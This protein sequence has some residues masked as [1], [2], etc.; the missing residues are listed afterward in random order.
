MTKYFNKNQSN[1]EDLVDD[2]Q[3]EDWSLPVEDGHQSCDVGQTLSKQNPSLHVQ[4]KTPYLEDDKNFKYLLVTC[5]YV[6]RQYGVTKLMGIKEAK[7]K[8]PGL[9]IVS[10]EDLTHYREMSYKISEFLQKYT[11]NVERLGFDENFLDVSE[12]VDQRLQNENGDMEVNGHIYGNLCKED[13]EKETELPVTSHCSCGCRSRLIIGSQ[14]ANEIREALNE[15]LGITCCAGISY[16]KLLSKL[17]GGQH[18]PNQQTTLFPEQTSEFML[19]LSR[20]RDIPGVGWTTSK[21]LLTLGVFSVANLQEVPL[22]DL[23]EEIG[24]ASAMHIKELSFGIDD[25]PVVPFKRPQTLSDEDSFKKCSTE[26]EVRSKVRELLSSLMIRLK[27]DGRIPHT[28]RLTIRRFTTTN[29]YT[30]RESRQC[31]ISSNVFS[32]TDD[33]M[34]QTVNKLLDIVMSLFHKLVNVNQSFHLTLINIAFCNLQDKAKK[35]IASFFSPTKIKNVNP[36]VQTENIRHREQEDSKGSENANKSAKSPPSNL[37]KWL[38]SFN[39]GRKNTLN[40]MSD[41]D[42]MGSNSAQTPENKLD[43]VTET[44]LETPREESFFGIGVKRK[45]DI[46]KLDEKGM[47][48]K[49]RFS[50]DDSLANGNTDMSS[51]NETRDRFEVILPSDI[52]QEVFSNLPFEVQQEVI[53][54]IKSKSISKTANS[55]E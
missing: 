40:Q 10:G 20:A 24:E 26:V 54:D 46:E 15:E 3:E 43:N 35:S 36:S 49:K 14:I 44:A 1:M 53:Q 31:P 8:C 22:S 38:N 25:S 13:Q 42:R 5:N 41:A 17:V 6:A 33:N 2:E 23:V 45:K 18:K 47:E 30:S 37:Q 21:K 19:H 50:I 34:E 27:E 4:D 12:M 16:N 52:D 51:Q 32:K 28:V 39:S 29:K 11:A 48:K 7:E 55:Q 9:V